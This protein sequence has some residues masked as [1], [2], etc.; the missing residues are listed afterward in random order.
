MRSFGPL[1]QERRKQKMVPQGSEPTKPGT[2]VNYRGVH[3]RDPSVQ[4]RPGSTA[5]PR[6]S[7]NRVTQ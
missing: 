2:E 4:R 6:A 7:V 3:A 5:S 1:T